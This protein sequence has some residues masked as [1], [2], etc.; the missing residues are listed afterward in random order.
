M[1]A[2]V[3]KVTA[4]RSCHAL[5][6]NDILVVFPEPKGHTLRLRD[7]LRF[8]T[9]ALDVTVRVTNLSQNEEFE[10]FV[11]S[12][13]VHDVRLPMKHG[14]SRTPTPERLNNP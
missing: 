12:I 14:G 7:Q 11:A 3:V 9:L 2:E 8:N 6:P 13:D 10:V 5:L 4:E 1:D